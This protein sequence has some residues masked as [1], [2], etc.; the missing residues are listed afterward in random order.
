MRCSRACVR[1]MIEVHADM[2]FVMSEPAFVR[3]LKRGNSLEFLA[4]PRPAVEK[5]SVPS[6]GRDQHIVEALSV[7][8]AVK[9]CVLRNHAQNRAGA[10]LVFVGE[11][12]G[13]ATLVQVV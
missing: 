1:T 4:S 10:E 7:G 13:D 5:I 8:V 11:S 12:D 6:L 2:D 3:E 9:T